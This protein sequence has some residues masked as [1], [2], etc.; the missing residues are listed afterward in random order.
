MMKIRHSIRPVTWALALGLLALASCAPRTLDKGISAQR[1]ETTYRRAIGDAALPQPWEVAPLTPVLPDVP[2]LQWKTINGEPHVRV[3]S[4]K[5]H[6]AYYQN[7][8]LTGTYNTGNYPIW[9]T[10][11]PQLQAR[12]QSPAFGRKMGVNLRLQQ[13]LGLPPTATHTHFVT[14]WVKPSDLF[15][16]CIDAEISDDRCQPAWSSEAPAA[17]HTQWINDLRL[18]SYFSATWTDNYPWTALGY[19]YDW[20]P[21]S[22]DHVGLSEYVIRKNA[23]IIVDAITPTAV[24]CGVE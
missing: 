23:T 5:S 7:D 3:V 1:W 19:T 8:S 15:R 10:L 12:C 4:W 16:P 18:Q 22:R 24:Y 17:D 13:L 20:H 2:D 6:I 11:A 9:V 21:K 14:F